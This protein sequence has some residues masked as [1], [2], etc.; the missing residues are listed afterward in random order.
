MTTPRFK[1]TVI[2]TGYPSLDEHFQLRRGEV[3]LL[4]GRPAIGKTAVALNFA[5]NVA[6]MESGPVG[7]IYLSMEGAQRH[8]E[9]RLVGMLANVPLVPLRALRQGRLD[10]GQRALFGKA[11]AKLYAT[12]IRL[13]CPDPAALDRAL[14]ETWRAASEIN[15]GLVIVDSLNMLR[16][17]SFFGVRRRQ[18][19]GYVLRSLRWLAVQLDVAVLA[20]AN[21]GRKADAR[22]D[23]RPRATDVRGGR[24]LANLADGVVLLHRGEPDRLGVSEVVQ[25]EVTVARPDLAI[26][27]PTILH[28]NSA[29]HRLSEVQRPETACVLN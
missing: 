27:P 10:S 18:G 28:M 16:S 19:A 4:A 20:H 25:F 13:I 8:L 11:L 22:A 2:A 5:L 15:A 23:K 17:D 21:L 24:S 1:S 6:T 3:Y 9:A 12:P 14:V 29:T 7:T 26:S